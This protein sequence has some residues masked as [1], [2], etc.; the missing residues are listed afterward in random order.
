M[1]VSGFNADIGQTELLQ[2]PTNVSVKEGHPVILTCEFNKPVDCSWSRNNSPLPINTKYRY[3]VGNDGKQTTNCSIEITKVAKIDSTTWV[4]SFTAK[5][6]KDDPIRSNAAFVNVTNDI[7]VEGIIMPS[8]S[9]TTAPASVPKTKKSDESKPEVAEDKPESSGANDK[10]MWISIAISLVAL[11]VVNTVIVVCYRRRAKS[12]RSSKNNSPLTSRHGVPQTIIIN[13]PNSFRHSQM[14]NYQNPH[15]ILR[16]EEEGYLQ[17][18]L[19]DGDITILKTA[20]KESYKEDGHNY[21][22]VRV[23]PQSPIYEEIND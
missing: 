11:S 18:I 14:P 10:I 5:S 16:L 22:N 19:S 20:K 12:R 9:S 21:Q 23:Q 17:P 3:I 8:S 6:D 15:E 1:L 13:R 7:P 2:S 4:C